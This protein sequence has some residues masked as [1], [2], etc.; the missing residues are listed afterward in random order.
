MTTVDLDIKAIIGLAQIN[1]IDALQLKNYLKNFSKE[2]MIDY[3]VKENI[4]EENI[5]SDDDI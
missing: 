4:E 2:E 3:L 5:D 1:S